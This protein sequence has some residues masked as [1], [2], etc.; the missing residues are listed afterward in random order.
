MVF[1]RLR[2][3]EPEADPELHILNPIIVLIHGT[4]SFT[5]VPA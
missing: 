4:E 3:T 1:L 2:G 5:T